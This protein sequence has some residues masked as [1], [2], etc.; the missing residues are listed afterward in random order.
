MGIIN[1]QN[2]ATPATPASGYCNVFTNTSKQLS[3]IDDMGTV[4]VTGTSNLTTPGSTTS[5]DIVLWNSSTGAAISDSGIAVAGGVATGLS[6]TGHAASLAISGQTGLLT[7]IGLTSTNRAKTVRDAADTILELGGSYTP[8]GAWTSMNL[9]TPTL[10]VA[11]A[12][13]VAASGVLS[14]GA[15]SGTNGQITLSGSTSGSCTLKVAAAAGTSTNFRLPSD[16]GTN[17]YVLQ[18]DGSGNTSWVVGG[19]GGS[20]TLASLTDV[21]DDLT[22]LNMILSGVNPSG[23]T[24]GTAKNNTSL[25]NGAISAITTGTH[26]TAIGYNALNG[27]TSG[28]FNL[29]LGSKCAPTLTNNTDCVVIGYQADVSAT[30]TNNETVIGSNAVGHGNATVTI[31]SAFVSDIY[32]GSGAGGSTTL[33]CGAITTGGGVWTLAGYT[34]GAPSATGYIT[35]TIGGTTYKL[36]AST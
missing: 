29:V 28:S 23:I 10:G 6:I 7:F 31:G 13:S 32:F 15:N 18:T 20:S 8:T 33:Q 19:G 30:T 21:I 9:I 1:I 3:W 26:N 24:T 34:G 4:N 11:T 2:Q 5:T 27:L 35:I 22:N 25:G 14:T 36:L 17:T 16:N 12:T